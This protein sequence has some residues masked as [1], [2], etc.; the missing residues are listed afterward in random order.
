MAGIGGFS[1]QTGSGGVLCPAILGTVLLLP[2]CSAPGT[3]GEEPSPRLA[4]GCRQV[5][6]AHGTGWSSF[7]YCL[8]WFFWVGLDGNAGRA[9]LG[10][11][12]GALSLPDSPFEPPALH[13]TRPDRGEERVLI[14]T[15][16]TRSWGQAKTP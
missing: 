13:Q 2:A 11:W 4:G 6:P 15:V 12:Q 5:M 14:R 10:P 16:K 3:A 9:L 7:P 1:I 8:S